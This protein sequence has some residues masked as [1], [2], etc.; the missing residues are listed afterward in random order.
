MAA[1]TVTAMETCWGGAPNAVAFT[2]IWYDPVATEADA[3]TANVA[4]SATLV[5][6]TVADS[7]GTAPVTA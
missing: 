6:T 2:K 5:G 1:V 7:P 4:L 3:L